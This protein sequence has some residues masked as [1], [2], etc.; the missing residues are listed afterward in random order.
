MKAPRSVISGGTGYVGRF[1]AENLLDAGHRVVV[2][3]R[4]AP[5]ENFF[6]SPVRYVPFSLGDEEVTHSLFE[7]ADF[8]VH[9]AFDHVPGRYRGGEGGDPEAFRRRNID[10]SVALFSAAKAA[11]V[12]RAVFLSSRAVYGRRP[13]GEWLAETDEPHPDTLYGIVKLE[14]EK[15]LE[16]LCGPGF[17]GISLRVT[18][19]YGPAGAGLP[20]KWSGLFA[21]YLS[22]EQIDPRVGTEVHGD[23]VAD[24]VR[25]V[26]ERGTI[27]ETLLNVSDLIVDRREILAILKRKSGASH[28]LPAAGNRSAINQMRTDRLRALGWRPGGFELL[29]RTI[30]ALCRM[31]DKS[32]IEQLIS[33]NVSPAS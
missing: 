29:Q 19:V 6:S 17:Q 10:G 16:R 21:D 22:G 28:S 24:A 23:D 26:L 4:N 20:H 18:G 15:A 33:Q 13:P 8:F 1:I 11:G 32:V 3:G 5:P 2:L 12:K 7:G 9:C 31:Y 27:D 14:A 25:L 30:A